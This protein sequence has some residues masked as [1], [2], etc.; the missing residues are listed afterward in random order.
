MHVLQ[1]PLRQ[2]H[3]RR[4]PGET[5]HPL[6]RPVPLPP[7]RPAAQVLQDERERFRGFPQNV[8][9]FDTARRQHHSVHPVLLR[10]H[11]EDPH[12]RRLV[13][14]LLQHFLCRPHLKG[15]A[16]GALHSD[17][18]SLRLPVG[19]RSHV[20]FQAAL[21]L[22][23]AAELAVRSGGVFGHRVRSAGR[24]HARPPVHDNEEAGEDGPRAGG[25]LLHVF[26]PGHIADP[27]AG[28]QQTGSSLF[29][30]SPLSAVDRADG[31][32]GPVVSGFGVKVRED[33][34]FRRDAVHDHIS[35][36]SAASEFCIII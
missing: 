11:T 14:I 12:G 27:A 35:S 34:H 23:A 25:V 4:R 36:V 2:V 33:H 18:R 1:R 6:L 30:G 15:V 24:F 32:A 13:H 7:S 10:V 16:Q 21:H 29:G 22:H 17:G 28:H 5:P 20:H 26:R 19:R 3:P 9:D 31:H 8:Q